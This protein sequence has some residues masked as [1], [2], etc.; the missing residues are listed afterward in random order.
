VEYIQVNSKVTDKIFTLPNLISVVRLLLVPVFVVLLVAYENNVAAFVLFLIAVLTDF[1]D[2]AVARSTGQVSKLG[3]QLDPIVDRILI[4]AAVV[5]VFAVGRV[6]LWIV[7]LL[8]ARDVLLFI[9]MARL[10]AAERQQFK[11][12]FIGKAATAI[13]MAGFCSLIL[14]W[15]QLGGLGLIEASFLPGFGTSE[16]PLGIWFL[17]LGV[18]L[19]W[20]TGIHYVRRSKTGDYSSDGG[21][22]NRSASSPSNRWHNNDSAWSSK[23]TRQ[24]ASSVK[25]P[26]NH[27]AAQ[28]DRWP[29]Q[30]NRQGGRQG[31]HQANRQGKQQASRQGGVAVLQVLNTPKKLL[32]AGVACLLLLSFL[33]FYGCDGVRNFGVIHHGVSVGSIDVS[34]MTEEEAAE[35]LAAEL[36]ALAMQAPINLYAS[37]G[38]A[39]HGVTINT[40]QLGNGVSDLN[41]TE[42]NSIVS[43]WSISPATLNAEVDGRQLAA[44][45][46][47]IGRSGDFFFGRL[48]ANIFG[49]TITPKIE[50]SEDRLRYLEE[51]LTKS[52]GNPMVNATIRFDGGRFVVVNGQNGRVVD[53]TR[54]ES[55]LQQAFFNE[56]REVIVPMVDR[57]MRVDKEAA[58]QVAE[59][60]QQIISEPVTLTY[61]GNNWTLLP[62]HLGWFINTEVIQDNRGNW[63][64]V[65]SVDA[66]LLELHLPLIIGQLEDQVTPL[67]A[68]FVVVE[69]L[70][71]ILPSQNGTGINYEQLTED[72]EELLFG[73]AS[74]AKDSD[75]N[76][77]R[78]VPI[79]IGVLEPGIK[80]SEAEAYDFSTRIGEYTLHY[81]YIPY[82]SVVNIHVAANHINSSIIAP[83]E[84][85]SLIESVG[86]FTAANGFV[87]AQIIVH[88]EYVDG[89]G[90]GVCT[91]ATTIFNAAWETGYPIIERVNHS[92]R[93]ERYPLG[94]D[95]AI[96]Y[97]YADLKFQ[98]DTDNYLLLTMTY[99]EDSITC[100]FW[101]VP[102]GYQVESIQGEFIEGADFIKLEIVDESLAPGQS[103]L[104]RAGLK[105]SKVEVTR[106]V[107]DAEGNVKEKRI[108]YSS[109]DATHEIVKVGP[110]G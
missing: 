3:Q 75:D 6:P 78:V 25:R 85:W 95:A 2:G 98:N 80:T 14:F 82:E 50:I 58:R 26:N 11:V 38:A 41:P 83:Q 39:L 62:E 32:I 64:L 29:Q 17:Y 1:V 81:P 96:A 77:N 69:G 33:V 40:L 65:P 110:G 70:L 66:A 108:F 97:P 57:L 86:E 34:A 8:I 44:E 74:A 106:I 46:Y 99:T 91:V 10:S 107:Y 7:V 63:R 89:M 103:Y 72:L 105:A 19:A 56:N 101:G 4:A 76:Q 24:A 84:T 22:R 93:A 71:Q 90:G 52:I 73:D 12:A 37:E 21:H 55:L 13:N 23:S 88:G 47:G 28:K 5:A 59:S 100:I 94:R 53:E 42:D 20:A 92:L 27:G 54:F 67:N 35:L 16:A 51:M 48:A 18:I 45:A 9:F 104:D 30:G 49:V 109:Y 60:I 31:S 87:D 43:S 36:G 15:P 68:E 102:P 61:T 79:Q